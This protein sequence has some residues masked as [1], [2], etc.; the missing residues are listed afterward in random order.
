M[1][2]SKDQKRKAYFLILTL[3]GVSL[4]LGSFI[5]LQAQ[6]VTKLEEKLAQTQSELKKLFEI[7][8]DTQISPEEKEKLEKEL[9]LKIILEIIE[10]SQTQLEELKHNWEKI[11]NFPLSED[12]QKVK[13]F[14]LKKI[15]ESQ[16]YWE[17]QKAYLKEKEGEL[18]TKDLKDLAKKIEEDK[19]SQI[20]PLI[21]RSSEIFM[22]FD[23]TE[24][25]EIANQRLE[26]IRVDVNK[27]YSKKMTQSPTL[28]NLLTQASDYLD[29]AQQYNDR[30]KELILHLY[31]PQE[32]DLAD[33]QNLI[34]EVRKQLRKTKG[35]FSLQEEGQDYIRE[36]ILLAFGK[37]KSSYELFLK[38]STLA[39]QLII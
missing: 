2:I 14:F 24:I 19:K 27:I 5:H 10:I 3:V 18:T 21:E 26:K 39:K 23:L 22:V 33:I 29:Q 6:S 32:K 12:W 36:L 35:D 7:K 25:L 38:M 1:F 9:R 15:D 4:F 16:G 8:D 20:N 34:E 11:P 30:S 31:D 13:E 37:V 17:S 28:K